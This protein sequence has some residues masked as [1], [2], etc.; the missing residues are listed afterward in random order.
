MTYPSDATAST[1]EQILFEIM[2]ADAV[3]QR[4]RANV[5]PD[6]INTDGIAGGPM[7]AAERKTALR[8]FATLNRQPKRRKPPAK[9]KPSTKAVPRPQPR[10]KSNG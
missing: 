6:L 4:R 1:P 7:T 5:R 3:E 8:K 10:R 9:R 2:T